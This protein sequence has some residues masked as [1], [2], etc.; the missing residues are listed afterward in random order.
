[1]QHSRQLMP[2]ILL[3]TLTLGLIIYLPPRNVSYN[4]NSDFGNMDGP[5][6]NQ[7]NIREIDDAGFE[8]AAISTGLLDPVIVEQ[9]GYYD[10][11]NLSGRTDTNVGAYVDVPIDNE[12]NWV[13]S[14]ADMALWN[15]NREYAE[16]GT[17]NDG[18][19]GSNTYPASAS[20][21]PYGWGIDQ[22]DPSGVQT[23]IS[24]YDNESEYVTVEN[25]G[26]EDTVPFLTYWHYHST[27]NLW[28][29]TIK[30]EPYSNNMTLSFSYNYLSGVINN[31]YAVGGNVLLTAW[32]E[33]STYSVGYI[34]VD[35]MYD[36]PSRNTWYDVV[37]YNITDVPTEFVFSIGLFVVADDLDSFELNPGADYDNDG[38]ID[39]DNTR[40]FKVQLDNVSLVSVTQPT[41]EQ[42]DLQ[43][44]AGTFST[45]ITGSTGQGTALIQNQ[46]WATSTLLAGISANVSVSFEYN[47]HLNSHYFSNSSYTPHPTNKGVA[48]SIDFGTSADLS[49]FT[50]IGGDLTSTYENFSVYI[51]IPED[52]QNATIYDPFTNDVTSSCILQ[53]G[54]IKIPTSI[55]DRLGWWEIDQQSPNYAKRVTSQVY[56]G[57]W[58]DETLFRSGNITRVQL[59]I[60][61]ATEIPSI[62]DWV[63]VTWKQP[64]DTV[65]SQESLSSAILGVVNS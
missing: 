8:P 22:Y 45:G 42:V 15:L 14:E 55:L 60:G 52:W 39:G 21:Y 29:Q 13:A 3:V 23:L 27:W 43:F 46:Y 65:W 35:L 54:L 59:E 10:T 24:Y 6:E 53:T 40:L 26:E 61:T 31:L 56:D 28:N 32:I 12:S 7:S 1:M 47:I 37:H 64:D 57:T 11:G 63:N 50:Y 18:I 44:H 62:S 51:Y 49:M 38:A 17:Y 58:S 16:N 41:P 5:L 48:Y 19:G 9:N 25:Q 4:S 2:L 20:A 36:T 34:L 30:N 33:N